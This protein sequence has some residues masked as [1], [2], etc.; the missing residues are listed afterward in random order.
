MSSIQ[1]NSYEDAKAYLEAIAL[2]DAV[3]PLSLEAFEKQLK[4][5]TLTKAQ[6]ADLRQRYMDILEYTDRLCGG[7]WRSD[8]R[9]L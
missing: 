4:K 3:T 8:R 5:L 2:T 9:F 7:I 6:A 1:W